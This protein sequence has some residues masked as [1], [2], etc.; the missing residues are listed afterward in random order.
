[1]N[2]FS[3]PHR[4]RTA[5]KANIGHENEKSEKRQRLDK[6]TNSKEE[7]EIGENE[8]KQMELNTDNC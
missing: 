5:K 8:M 7:I 3:N 1:M 6:N 2:F 4:K